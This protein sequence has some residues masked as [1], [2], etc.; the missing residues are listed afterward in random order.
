MSGINDACMLLGRLAHMGGNELL[1]RKHFNPA[2]MNP[3]G[4]RSS[5]QVS[6]YSIAVGLNGNQSFAAD[7]HT[8]EKAI[9]TGD[10]GQRTKFGLFFRQPHSGR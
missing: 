8:I 7:D 4:E 2:A 6:W 1:V 9:V 3:C 5:H 10:S